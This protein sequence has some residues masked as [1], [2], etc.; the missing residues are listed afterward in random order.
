MHVCVCGKESHAHKEAAE[1]NPKAPLTHQYIVIMGGFIHS[2]WIAKAL[3][4]C[5]AMKSAVKRH[6]AG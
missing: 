3:H 5:A 2:E 4:C 6:I 1:I